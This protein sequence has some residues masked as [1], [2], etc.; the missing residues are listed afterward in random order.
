MLTYIRIFEVYSYVLNFQGF[1]S[2][3]QLAIHETFIPEILLA[4][5]GLH[6]LEIMIHMNC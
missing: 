3:L 4:N 2:Q 6:R 5:F 1:H